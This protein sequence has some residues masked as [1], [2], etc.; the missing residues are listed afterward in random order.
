VRK[1]SAADTALSAVISGGLYAASGS[2]AGFMSAADFS[3]LALY[4]A[5]SGLTTGQVPHA[6]GA[7][8][9][10]F[11]ALDPSVAAAF[12]VGADVPW[13]SHK[14]TGLANG[15]AATDAMAFGQ[16]TFTTVNA[17]LAAANADIAVNS[18]KLTGLAA[19]TG[20]GNSVRYEQAG[21]IDGTNAWTADQSMGSHKLTSV[22][23]PSSA[24]DAATKNYVD[25]KIRALWQTWGAVQNAAATGQKFLNLTTTTTS[26]TATETD[27]QIVAGFACTAK[28]IYVNTVAA[29]L[30]TDT[31]AITMRINGADSALTCTVAASGSTC[32]L[33]GQ[34]VAVAATDKISIGYVESGT[35]TAANIKIRAIIAGTVP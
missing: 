25:T 17:L 30:A 10:A 24:Q 22:T 6:T 23:D 34:S 7:A 12:S 20:A 9:L 14:I 8:T 33:T 13:S 4:P 21:L 29:A 28:Q 31:Q 5:V 32:N 35:Q 18:H 16:F 1:A 27:S 11:G 26:P 2:G 3:K 15:S 19:G